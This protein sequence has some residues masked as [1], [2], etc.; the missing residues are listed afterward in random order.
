VLGAG[1]VLLVVLLALCV[2]VERS[3]LAD[4][5]VTDFARLGDGDAVVVAVLLVLEEALSEWVV[6][7]VFASVCFALV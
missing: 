2:D 1:W 3:L 5:C 6:V 7:D 4:V